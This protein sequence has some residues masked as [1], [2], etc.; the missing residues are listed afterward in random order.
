MRLFSIISGLL[1]LFSCQGGNVGENEKK[2]EYEPDSP[3]RENASKKSSSGE[4]SSDDSFELIDYFYPS[5]E[6]PYIYAFIDKYNPLNERFFRFI[7]LEKEGKDVFIIEMYN[8]T[9]RIFEGFTLASDDSFEI[10]DH[11]KV[12]REGIKRSSRITK[13]KYFPS[14]LNDQSVFI[15]DFPSHLDSIIMIYESRKSV[16]DKNFELDV[17]G[18]KLPAIKIVDSVRVHMV[19]TYTKATSTQEAPVFR[20]YAK[21]MGE[22]RFEGVG[23]DVRYDLNKILTDSWWSEYAQ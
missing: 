5:K 3:I 23:V 6:E 2:G 10:L 12:D 16:I 1:L 15:A 14:N 21:G 9:L 8:E 7:N 11:M 18:K 4:M 13:N 20:Y 22:V 17:L 19:N